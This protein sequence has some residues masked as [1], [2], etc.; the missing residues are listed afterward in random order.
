[1]IADS[2]LAAHSGYAINQNTWVINIAFADGHAKHRRYLPC[3]PTSPPA[4][5]KPLNDTY[6][7][8][9]NYYSVLP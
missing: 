7:D 9:A 4:T 8:D 3:S 5:A 6:C 2:W 1:M